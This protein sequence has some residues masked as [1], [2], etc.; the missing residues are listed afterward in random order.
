MSQ[1]KNS[2]SAKL[3]NV[4]RELTI[5][6]KVLEGQ[7]E[8]FNEMLDPDT[9]KINENNLC[10][11]YLR[12]SIVSVMQFL[13]DLREDCASTINQE[14]QKFIEGQRNLSDWI[15]DHYNNNNLY[16][17][18]LDEALE[19][20]GDRLDFTGFTNINFNEF[21]FLQELLWIIQHK[22]ILW[23][24]QVDYLVDHGFVIFP[25]EDEE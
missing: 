6:L 18:V 20:M 13:K 24:E 1:K 14:Y 23:E 21:K 16:N 17:K 19:L 8:S 12:D 4:K 7:L 5:S 2:E 15:Y 22:S 10:D 3:N 9:T 25:K 11:L